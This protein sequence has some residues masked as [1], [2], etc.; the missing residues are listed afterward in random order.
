MVSN[1]FK[2]NLKIVKLAKKENKGYAFEAPHLHVKH[3][4]AIMVAT[5]LRNFSSPYSFNS[6]YLSCRNAFRSR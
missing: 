6:I 2:N 5:N 1:I 3:L 4:N